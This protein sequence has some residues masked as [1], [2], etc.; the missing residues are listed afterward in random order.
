M[1]LFNVISI[2]H[3]II[4]SSILVLRNMKFLKIPVI[5]SF[6]NVI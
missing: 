6:N 5:S 1:M 3:D 2:T 4:S